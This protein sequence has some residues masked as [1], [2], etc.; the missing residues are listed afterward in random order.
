MIFDKMDARKT[1]DPIETLERIERKL[2]ALLA[3]LAND[4][5]AEDREEKRLASLD[6]GEPLDLASDWATL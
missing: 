5:S 2:D 3:A 1:A 4:V 6:V